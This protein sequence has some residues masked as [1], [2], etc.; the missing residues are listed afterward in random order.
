[1]RK[2]LL[3]LLGG[4]VLLFGGACSICAIPSLPN[5][6]FPEIP[7]YEVGPMQEYEETIPAAGI[8]EAEVEIRAGVGEIE[9][10][11][12][13]PENL[14]SGRF[15]TN[16][17][18]W[19]PEVTWED[20]V[21]R[22]E[23]GI[24]GTAEPGA[25]NEWELGFSPDVPLDMDIDIGAA[26]GRLDFTGLQVTS[27]SLD[28]GASDIVVSFDEPNPA[29]MDRMTIRTGAA[30]LRVDGVGNGSPER[31]RV[32][33]GVGD[34]L[35]DLS[36]AWSHSAE[37]SITAGVGNLTL[38]LPADVG[39]RVT[40]EGGLGNIDAGPGL[41][42]SEDGSYVN[43]AYGNTEIE[44]LVEVTLGVGGMSMELVEE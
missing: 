12:G 23:Q 39:V 3:L 27:L 31:M 20:G 17:E 28:A 19:A 18:E 7:R 5:I 13:E 9:L 2:G 24:E 30:S 42:L 40:A 26:K 33:G 44:V 6:E 43:S 29:E 16:V 21:L 25:E 32:E 38:R 10:G 14:F 41:T 15:R 36:G 11:Q 1:M 4:M 34:I 22:I 37:V 35:L 8:S